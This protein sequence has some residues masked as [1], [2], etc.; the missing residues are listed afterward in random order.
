MKLETV[1]RSQIMKDKKKGNEEF[2]LYPMKSVVGDE[3]RIRLA[4]WNRLEELET[5]NRRTVRE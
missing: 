2:G 4:V 3:W 1:H 5:T